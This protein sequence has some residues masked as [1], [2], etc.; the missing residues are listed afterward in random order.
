VTR[1]DGPPIWAGAVQPGSVH[2]LVC[3]HAHALGARYAAAARGLPTLTDP[4][5]QGAG[6]GIPTPLTQPTDARRLDV[7]NRTHH[8]LLRSRRALA[9]RGLERLCCA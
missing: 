4:G 1:P 5:Y 8:A 7:D 9:D 6:I 2:D 3:A